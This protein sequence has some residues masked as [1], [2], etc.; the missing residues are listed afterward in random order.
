MRDPYEV[1]G[2]SRDSDPDALRE[3]YNQLKRQYGEQRFMDGE[4]GNEGARLLSELESSW[5]LI[6]QDLKSKERFK[7]FG[8]DYGVVENLIRSGS[9]DEA[10]AMMDSIPNR[11]AKWHYYQSII[12]YKRDWISESRAQLV[13]ALQLDPNNAKYRESLK[14]IDMVMSNSGINPNDIGNGAY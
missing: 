10:Q 2:M 5:T 14:K 9:Y 13:L 4:A 1:L 3:R 7:N 6:E 12:F 11:D 8:G